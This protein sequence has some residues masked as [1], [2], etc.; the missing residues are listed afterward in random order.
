ML[1]ADPHPPFLSQK[2]WGE[3]WEAAFLEAVPGT[4]R[5]RGSEDPLPG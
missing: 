5:V 3:A 4:R 2:V 1:S